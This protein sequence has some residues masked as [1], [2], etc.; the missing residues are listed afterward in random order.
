[1]RTYARLEECA[2]DALAGGES[3]IV[4]AAF[5]KGDERRRM[6]AL[7]RQWSVPAAIVHCVAPRDVLRSRLERR[8]RSGTDASEA[9]VSILDRQPGFWEGFAGD[10]RSSVVTVHTESADATQVALDGLISLG[11]R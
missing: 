6:L 10:E 9:G 11:I 8:A 5:L 7:A 3:V 4:D 2:A 1:V